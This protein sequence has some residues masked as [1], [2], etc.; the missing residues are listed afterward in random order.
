MKHVILSK[1]RRLLWAKYLL[2]FEKQRPTA[3]QLQDLNYGTP[4]RGRKDDRIQPI[5]AR[6]MAAV[7]AKFGHFVAFWVNYKACFVRCRRRFW[8]LANYRA[9]LVCERHLFG[10]FGVLDSWWTN[11]DLALLFFGV[12]QL[13]LVL[14]HPSYL[15]NRQGHLWSLGK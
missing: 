10:V 8:L 4:A 14:H 13:L 9:F 7:E 2:A 6:K 5:W 1:A 12:L 11:Y 3:P 15:G